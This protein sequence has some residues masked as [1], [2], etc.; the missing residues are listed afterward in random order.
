MNEMRVK[1]DWMIQF[2]VKISFEAFPPSSPPSSP[3]P[4]HQQYFIVNKIRFRG[5]FLFDS[6]RTKDMY[7]LMESSQRDRVVEG[8][9][10]LLRVGKSISWAAA[11]THIPF[12]DTLRK[13]LN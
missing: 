8:Q 9:E 2:P 11:A 7:D 5:S 6:S 4:P 1:L 13:A 12:E 3:P 10:E